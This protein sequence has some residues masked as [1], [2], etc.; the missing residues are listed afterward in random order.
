MEGERDRRR[1]PERPAYPTWLLSHLAHSHIWLPSFQ[2]SP[3]IIMTLSTA[4]F[5][6]VLKFQGPQG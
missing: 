3:T 5:V 6:P 2:S 4:S 1:R